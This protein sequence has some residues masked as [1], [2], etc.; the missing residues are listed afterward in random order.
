MSFCRL[1]IQGNVGK[2]P[3]V[4]YTADGK[5]VANFSLAVSDKRGQNENV[6]WFRCTAFGKTAEIAGEYLKKGYPAIVDGRI[7]CRRYTDKQGVEKESWEVAVD[8]LQLLGKPQGKND[9]PAKQDESFD[10][11]ENDIPF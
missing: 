8:R 9:K 1:I 11:L 4:R 7:Q 10:S 2:E 6:T 3:E 5:S